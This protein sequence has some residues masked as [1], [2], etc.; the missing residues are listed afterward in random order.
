MLSLAAKMVSAL[1]TIKFI[2]FMPP[3]QG[4][5]VDALACSS[6]ENFLW[7]D[8]RTLSVHSARRAGSTCCAQSAPAGSGSIA[9]FTV[10]CSA[11]SSDACRKHRLISYMTGRTGKLTNEGLHVTWT[12]ERS[13][14]GALMLQTARLAATQRS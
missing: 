4:S 11:W 2:R 1:C 9:S 13:L 7:L 5:H 14:T 10:R 12:G 8:A 6:F 3:A